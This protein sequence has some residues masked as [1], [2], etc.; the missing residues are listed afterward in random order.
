VQNQISNK[1]SFYSR[2]SPHRQDQLLQQKINVLSIRTQSNT[3]PPSNT[4]GQSGI[5]DKNVPIMPPV[6]SVL[7][8]INVTIVLFTKILFISV[9][10]RKPKVTDYAASYTKNN[11]ISAMRAIH[12]YLLKPS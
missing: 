8:G 4:G 6:S 5:S 1:V 11:F 3:T 9:R 12:E 2:L 7:K 10:T